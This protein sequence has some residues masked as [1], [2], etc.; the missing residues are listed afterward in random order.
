M[1]PPGPA[2]QGHRRAT[3]AR[4]RGCIAPLAG[5]ALIP[6]SVF[7]LVVILT[8]WSSWSARGYG[9]AVLG[10]DAGLLL[11][12]P[13]RAAWLGVGLLALV[14]VGR[15]LGASR[16]RS[17]TMTCARGQGRWL[18]R[19]VDERDAAIWGARIAFASGRF[20]DPDVPAVVPALI[21]GYRELAD[22]EGDVPSPVVPT[23][24]G[25][26]R[27][28]AT[29]VLAFDSVAGK[30]GALIFLHGFGG[31]FTLPCWQVAQAVATVGFVT[32]CPSFGP[33]GDWWTEQGEGIVRETIRGLRAEGVQH[34]VLAGLSA[35]GVGAARMAPKLR[36]TID[37]LV[38]IS[39]AAPAGPP[40]VPVLVLQGPRDSMMP[41]SGAREYAAAHGATYVE[42]RGGHFA[43][44][45]DREHAMAA[46]TG[47]LAKH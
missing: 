37:G 11:K 27:S 31:G 46:L 22:H 38:L 7:A 34:V 25:L 19:V 8:P 33:R 42:L 4:P 16:G 3:A 43:M 9:L 12:P 20:R 24:L 29:D 21:G 45:L 35:G 40:G 2:V 15:V 5:L 47:W 28:G 39:G 13:R 1:R 36:G 17:L 18:A 23:Y 10:I 26:E 41:A 30:R 6:L 44:L 32:R 14:L